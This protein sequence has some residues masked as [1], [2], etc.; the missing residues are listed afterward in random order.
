MIPC[1]S[2]FVFEVQR[3]SRYCP[4]P[5]ADIQPSG[6][7]YSTAFPGLLCALVTA[8]AWPRAR[9]GGEKLGGPPPGRLPP[10]TEAFLSR[11]ASKS[12]EEQ[13]ALSSGKAFNGASQ[14]R[15]HQGKK[16]GTINPLF[17]NVP[18]S[19]VFTDALSGPRGSPAFMVSRLLPPL[20]YRLLN[21]DVG[22]IPASSQWVKDLTL[23][24]AV[25]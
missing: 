1:P 19:G 2:I 20:D 15:Q 24:G 25:V 11:R 14:P 9:I 6:T 17:E 10:P 21:E 23:L 7:I 12:C 22:S 4:P 16:E 18:N 8:S 13:N 5:R 3:R